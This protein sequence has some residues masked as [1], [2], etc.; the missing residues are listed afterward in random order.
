MQYYAI[1]NCLLA[2]KEGSITQNAEVQKRPV[3]MT[4][5]PEIQSLNFIEKLTFVCNQLSKYNL[6]LNSLVYR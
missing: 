6:R 3:R 4:H 5:W 2:L 1:D